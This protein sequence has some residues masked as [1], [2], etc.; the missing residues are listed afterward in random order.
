MKTRRQINR[1][2]VCVVILTAL[3]FS[4]SA[5]ANRRIVKVGL[6]QNRPKVFQDEAGVPQGI[7]IDLLNSVAKEENW[8]LEFSPGTWTE[9]LDR[10]SRGEIDLMPD[11]SFTPERENQWAFNREPVLSDWFQVIYRHNRPVS[12]ILDLAEKRVAVL[13]D[14]VQQT[15]FSSMV[16]DFDL[17]LEIVPVPNYDVG[18]QMIHTGEADV[19][20]ANRYLAANLSSE[21]ELEAS[22][23]IFNPTRLHFAAPLTGRRPLLDAIDRNL[24]LW[25]ADSHSIYYS[26]LKRWTGEKPKTITPRYV[27][28]AALGAGVIVLLITGIAL[29]FQRQVRIRT[30]ELRKKTY[31]LKTAL[32]SLTETQDKAIQQERLHALGEMAGGI[33]HDFNNILT[34]VIGLADLMLMNPEQIENRKI[35]RHYLEII[36]KAGRDGAEIVQRMKQF[37]RTHEPEEPRLIDPCN[38][39]EHIIELSRSRWEQPD[40]IGSKTIKVQT[41]LTRG[42]HILVQEA[43]LKEALVNLLFNAIDAMPEGGTIMLEVQKNSQEVIIAVRDTGTGMS[44]EVKNKC[45]EAFYTTKGQSGTGIGLSVVKAMCAHS[46][47]DIEIESA[48]GSGTTF[49]LLFPLQ[50]DP[51]ALPAVDGTVL[52]RIRPLKILAVDDELRAVEVLQAV[53]KQ[54]RHQVTVTTDAGKAL[55]MACSESYDLVI[56]DRCMP[57]FSGEDL[58]NAIRALPS[59]PPVILLTGTP[60]QTE[61][62]KQ[63]QVHVLQK[64]LDIHKLNQLLADMGFGAP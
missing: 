25:K 59:A 40:H 31:A 48:E 21:T 29:L 54:N 38:T 43:E 36:A 60:A 7:F 12:S 42:L 15:T 47:A 50:A 30:T 34:P 56:T 8:T 33:A 58:A 10:L 16:R 32:H 22:P 35:V 24:I 49:S 53:L 37:Y 9:G 45:M 55:K 26:S 17:R 63:E 6:Y 41:R 19:L 52:C 28:Y 61:I 46:R 44:A 4:L 11:V 14:S 64:P 57:D 51:V 5:Q 23:V 39:I 13:H 18:F 2:K 62:A 1:W 20:I 3:L 27:K